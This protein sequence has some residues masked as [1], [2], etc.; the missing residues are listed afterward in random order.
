MPPAK[1]RGRSLWLILPVLSI[2]LAIWAC[3]STP[4]ISHKAASQLRL[5][6]TVTAQYTG[7][8][9]I[10]LVNV[11]LYDNETNQLVFAPTDAHLTCE[12]AD[13]TPDY[14]KILWECPRQPAGGAYHFVYIDEHGTA[15]SAVIPVPKGTVA[16]L[17]PRPGDH[18]AIPT[19]NTLD[20]R[21]T[22]PIPPPDGSV[23][24]DE[25]RALCD[26]TTRPPCSDVIFGQP[27]KTGMTAPGGN[28]IFQLT[29]DFSSI[30]P[31]D[32]SVDITVGIHV[33]P[34]QSGFARVDVTFSDSV[35]AP[36]TW[37]R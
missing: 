1:R 15:T 36:I 35:A 33:L 10:V 16:L 5:E 25:A 11:K 34:S 32:G 24:V 7:N 17:A 22:A 21:Y 3:G 19:A 2:A 18:V 31:G 6:I 13:V 29:G 4:A 14:H 8:T 28:G 26:D 27:F 30:Q 12:G 23:S 37:T 9:D 20:I